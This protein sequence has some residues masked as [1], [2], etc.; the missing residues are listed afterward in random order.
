M[1][2]AERFK[3]F[4]DKVAVLTTVISK[5]ELAAVVSVEFMG[6]MAGDLLWLRQIVASQQACQ[7]TEKGKR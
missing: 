7:E 1:T 4:E 2:D 3:T 5:T 6:G